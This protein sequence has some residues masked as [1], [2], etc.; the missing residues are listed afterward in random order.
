M[1]RFFLI[2]LTLL[3]CTT[4]QAQLI[5]AKSSS[6]VTI[7]GTNYYVH[8]V[9]KG[10]TV[11]SLARLYGVTEEELLRS[12]P[13][14]VEGLQ[15]G[16]VLKIRVTDTKP[17][18]KPKKMARLFD[19]HTV[20]QGETAYA[21][22]KRYGISV[23]TLIED[24]P[25]MDPAA[26]SIGQ[27]LNIR[28]AEQGETSEAQLNTEWEQYRDAINSVSDDYIYHL[29]A[30]GE[31][32]YSLS[33]QFGVTQA[34]IMRSND[35]KDG[36]KMGALIRIPNK[37]KKQ[38]PTVTEQPVQD[39]IVMPPVETELTEDDYV[40]EVPVRTFLPGATLNV[41]LMLPLKSDSG[42]GRHFA[43]FYRGVLLGLADIKTSGQ[44]VNLTLF[45]TGKSEDEVNEIVKRDDFRKSDLII[46]PVYEECFPPV[47]SFA[48][49]RGIP[50][51]SPLAV[52]ENIKSPLLYQMAPDPACKYDKMQ[53]LLTGEKNIV[54]VSTADN[55]GEFEREIIP[56]LPKEYQ[57]LTYTKNTPVSALERM[58]R[59]D[60]DNVF[61][62]LS[63]NEYT[64]DQILARISSVQNN[65]VARSIKNAQIRIIGSSRWVRFQNID[66]NLF[67]KLG[68]S[69]VTSYHAD[70]S[71]PVVNAFDKQYVK[72]FGTLPSLY[73]YRGYDAV[74][75]FVGAAS[76]SGDFTENVNRSQQ[77]LLQMSYRFDH[78]SSDGVW[79]NDQWALVCYLP[80]YTIEVR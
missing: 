50:I 68:L 24:N 16:Q 62:V 41:A 14:A 42:L 9:K 80:D 57:T 61:V 34:E 79:V 32:V 40:T 64:V 28:K 25:G 6:I 36:L 10:D 3:L 65:L 19:T 73:A 17:R 26:L 47:L 20:N 4:G 59:D 58:I 52:V 1:K 60:R 22:S 29:V 30:K 11:Y 51:V 72:E 38:G 45:N 44:S 8:T 35:L 70:R 5:K 12:N 53:D 71:N 37:S 75:L 27:Q 18:L 39:S 33:R 56:L 66:K 21:I 23:N 13:Q 43:D 46:G 48:Q 15:L 49:Q 55:D 76:L 31:T 54:V 74:K 77:H 67:F 69:F 2:A 63:G 7:E 78:D